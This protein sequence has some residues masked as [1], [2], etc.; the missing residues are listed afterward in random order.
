M[1]TETLHIRNFAG[2]E[3]VRIE[4]KPVTVLIGP[5]ASG[6]SVCAKLVFFFKELIRRLPLHVVQERNKSSLR[7]D[8]RRLFLSYFPPESWSSGTFEIT[9]GYGQLRIT[10]RRKAPGSDAVELEYSPYY[11]HV[12]VAGRNVFRRLNMEDLGKWEN[13]TDRVF[14]VSAVQQAIDERLAGDELTVLANAIYFIPAGRSFFATLR[15]NVFSYIASAALDPFLVEFGRVY[16]RVRR[17]HRSG[18]SAD[19][20]WASP[21][22]KRVEELLRGTY[23]REKDDDFIQTTDGRRV[24]VSVSSSGQQEVLPMALV[25]SAIGETNGDPARST[26]FVEEPEA[27]LFPTA[28]RQI[29]HLFATV[30]DLMAAS[31]FSQY[32]IT[33]HSPYILSALNNLMYGGKI[34]REHDEKREDVLRLLGPV[35]IDPGKV[36]AYSM[37]NGGA[38]SMIDPETRLVEATLID[39]VSGDLAREF[40]QLVAIEFGG[41]AG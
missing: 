38:R 41:D 12:L 16:E 25:L 40:E 27:H 24:P 9:Y 35:L 26:L 33:T 1:N 32:I 19:P 10:A 22:R 4:L 21:I 29:V 20:L 8:D 2:L 31:S 23:V 28:Q 3:E 15:S 39:R 34:A 17:R 18:E 37:E 7:A 13:W 11:D 6:K 36:D 14:A 30:T 5:Q